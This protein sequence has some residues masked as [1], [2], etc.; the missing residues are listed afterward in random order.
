MTPLEAKIIIPVDAWAH[1]IDRFWI[2]TRLR[3]IL[4]DAGLRT[5]WD[6]QGLKYSVVSRFRNCGPK[7]LAELELFVEALQKGLLPTREPPPERPSPPEF[8]V[9]LAARHL[10]VAHLPISTRLENVLDRANISTLGQLDGYSV[11]KFLV[12]RGC[13]PKTLAEMRQFL[14]R[15]ATGEFQGPYGGL[16][17]STVVQLVRL[18]DELLLRLTAR[19]RRIL[20]LR[21]GGYGDRPPSFEAIGREFRISTEGI[22]QMTLSSIQRMQR[23]GRPKLVNLSEQFRAWRGQLSIPFTPDMLYE[24]AAGGQGLQYSPEFYLRLLDRLVPDQS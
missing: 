22:R 13:G 15:A 18:I 17:P 5:L 8:K 24:L 20:L 21:L 2:S 19:D 3:H 10:K 6:L 14:A 12:I 1:T 7:T 4:Q 23:L 11:L 9:P 16:S